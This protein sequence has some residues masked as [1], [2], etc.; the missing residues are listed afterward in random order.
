MGVDQGGAAV[1]DSDLVAVVED[2][3]VLAVTVLVDDLVLAGN[4]R[5]KVKV[6]GLAAESREARV[7]RFPVDARGLDEVLRRKAA[8]V[9]ARTSHGARLG[10]RR[11]LAELRGLY[12]GGERGRA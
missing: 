9:H 12:R 7:L 2:R 11:C 4:Q 10:H 6:E 5:P 8:A 3:L 1:V